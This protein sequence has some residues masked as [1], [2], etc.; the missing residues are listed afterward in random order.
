MHQ[1]PTTACT[2][3]DAQAVKAS[4]AFL[5]DHRILA[6]PSCGATLAMVYEKTSIDL[7][8]YDNIV[9]I[10]CGGSGVNTTMLDKWMSDFGISK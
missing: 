1:H 7:A 9:V 3:S 6:E 2:V 4:Y 5:N 8:A 10:V